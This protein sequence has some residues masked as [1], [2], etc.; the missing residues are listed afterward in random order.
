YQQ[1]QQRY[2]I[3]WK[4]VSNGTVIEEKLPRAKTSNSD[5][6]QPGYGQ[7]END[8]LHNMIEYKSQG[9][10]DDSTYRY[11]TDG[12][13][14]TYT[15][16]VDDTAP[17]TVLS[18]KVR[19]A[20]DGK[21][22]RVRVGDTVLFSQ[23]LKAS[24]DAKDV[25]DVK[26][27]IPQDVM[28]RCV[29]AKSADGKDYKVIDVTFSSNDGDKESAKVCDF[30]YMTAVKPAYEYDSTTAYFVDCGDQNT[31]TLTGK[32][33]LG[34]YNCVTEQLYGADEVTGAVWG[35]IDDAT[36]QYNGSSKGGGI[37]TAN[38]WCDESHAADGAAKNTS[39]RYTK[40]QYEN[41]IDR[42]LDYAFA[43]PNGSYSVE[44][45]FAD[46]WSCSKNPTVYA[47]L[48]EAD[49]SVIAKNCA[50]GSAVKGTAKVTNGKLTI[51]VR[52]EDKAINLCYIII[53]P[54][55]VTANVTGQ[56]GDVNLD[57]KV[58][59]L[60]AVALQKYLL[61]Q[62]D[63]TGENAFAADICSDAVPDIYDLAALKRTLLQ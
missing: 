11:A 40:N 10:T 41:S 49:E 12:G 46:P 9:V 30:I 21:T 5:T 4:F 36:D 47:N 37:Y 53:K 3:Y 42:H 20:D 51:N 33:K 54:E 43:L 18:F 17:M 55:E 7:Y 2:G 38:T 13:W 15:M 57:G 26:L 56:K 35:L 8:N 48:G 34:L 45:A 31:S 6:V 29:Y 16:A 59:V 58:D 61:G 63:F 14:F 32:D 24:A 28:N 60:D 27:L 50:I 39:F 23:A 25:Y 62:K 1:Y 22:L 44:V 19:K 52:S